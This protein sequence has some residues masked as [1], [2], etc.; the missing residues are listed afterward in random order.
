LPIT[1]KKTRRRRDELV[2]RQLGKS[3]KNKIHG[4]DSRVA[5]WAERVRLIQ[6]CYDRLD[7]LRDGAPSVSPR[8]SAA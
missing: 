6:H 5:Y 7:S 8:K 4:V 1:R 3:D 2:W